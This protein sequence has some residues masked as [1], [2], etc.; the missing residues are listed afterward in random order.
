MK[1]LKWLFLFV[2]STVALLLAM[3]SIPLHILFRAFSKKYTMW[4]YFKQLSIA[5]DVTIGSIV[6]GSRHTI[7]AI[8]GLKAYQGST[9]Y[10]FQAK[11]IDKL[12]GKNHCYESAVRNGFIL[13]HKG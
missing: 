12:F 9:Y 2:F 5:N 13:G 4:Y 10:K 3:V 7:S 8:T 1:T 6:Y 11:V